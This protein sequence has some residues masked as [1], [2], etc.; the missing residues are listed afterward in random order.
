MYEKKTGAKILEYRYVAVRYCFC[1]ALSCRK[2]SYDPGTVIPA[3][4]LLILPKEPMLGTT[5]KWNR[6]VK[7]PPRVQV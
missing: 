1:P 5:R 2:N 4:H 7:I 3:A 6:R